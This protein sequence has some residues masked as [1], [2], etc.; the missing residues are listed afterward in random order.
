M[1]CDIEKKKKI[2]N[3]RLKCVYKKFKFKLCF[4]ASIIGAF[5]LC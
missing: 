5:V 1:N 4:I 2:N 3:I